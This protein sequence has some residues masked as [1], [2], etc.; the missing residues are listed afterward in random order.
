MNPILENIFTRRS[1]RLFDK[2]PIP[3]DVMQQIIDAGNMAPTGMNT[4]NWRFVVV[5]NP[6]IR[7]K[8]TA[9]TIPKYQAWLAKAPESLQ[10]MRAEIDKQVEDPVYYS[11]ASVVFILGH[12]MVKDLDCP[13]V[14]QNMMLAAR[15]FGIGSCW[16]YMGQ[17]ALTDDMVRKTLDIKDGETVYGPIIFG[18][19]KD[20]KFPSVPPKKSAVVKWA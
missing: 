7:R 8:F 20:G 19:P 3:K 10:K 13:M 6:E 5:E 15:S 16:V 11:A 12:G 1:V 2:K 14:C 4:Q 18:Y 17:L 9:V